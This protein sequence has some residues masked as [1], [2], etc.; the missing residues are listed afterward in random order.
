MFK[1]QGR[2]KLLKDNQGGESLEPT[3]NFDC[4]QLKVTNAADTPAI[5][6]LSSFQN[7]QVRCLM[8]VTLFMSTIELESLVIDESGSLVSQ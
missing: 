8:K 2:V 6:Q 5:H 3:P 1:L 4:H 7:S